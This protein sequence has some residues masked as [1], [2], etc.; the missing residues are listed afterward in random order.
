M[1]SRAPPGRK[2]G[3]SHSPPTAVGCLEEVKATHN[4]KKVALSG[5]IDPDDVYVLANTLTSTV[6]LPGN[7]PGASLG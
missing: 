1:G 5:G 2:G 7:L 3:S 6:S 4:S